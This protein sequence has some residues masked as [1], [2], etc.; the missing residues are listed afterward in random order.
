M[1]T[2]VYSALTQ[3]MFRAFCYFMNPSSNKNFIHLLFFDLIAKKYEINICKNVL[4]FG[5]KC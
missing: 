3:F 2:S 4:H 5:I 1:D